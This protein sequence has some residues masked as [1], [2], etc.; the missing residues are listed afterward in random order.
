MLQILVP[1]V[2]IEDLQEAVPALVGNLQATF[3]EE[4]FSDLPA[5]D[6]VTK[7]NQK[8]VVIVQ[9]KPADSNANMPVVMM[10]DWFHRG[11]DKKRKVLLKAHYEMV[12]RVCKAAAC[13]QPFQDMKSMSKA[14]APSVQLMLAAV[15][16]VRQSENAQSQAEKLATVEFNNANVALLASEAAER[17]TMASE[18][19]YVL[20]MKEGKYMANINAEKQVPLDQAKAAVEKGR[21][22]IKK[23]D[24][25]L[26]EQ[27]RVHAVPVVEDSVAPD[28]VATPHQQKVVRYFPLVRRRNVPKRSSATKPD[29]K[30]TYNFDIKPQVAQINSIK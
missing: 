1:S 15:K 26:E 10:R 8:A 29:Y 3:A 21:E 4:V 13:A 2:D 30:F 19:A 22:F 28:S 20:K 27:S 5:S 25:L 7:A 24:A 16:E 9:G 14:A 23:I 18:E 17:K 11:L 6:Q 12:S